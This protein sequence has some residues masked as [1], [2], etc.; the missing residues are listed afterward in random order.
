M[1]ESAH[2]RALQASAAAL[3]SFEGKDPDASWDQP[4]R[5]AVVVDGTSVYPVYRQQQW[6]RY[7]PQAVAA[8]TAYFAALMA[9]GYELR[10]TATGQVLR[11]EDDE[12]SK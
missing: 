5:A 2:L 1:D 10:P 7:Y 8:V 11:H 12:C 3:C 9:E 6:E 4:A